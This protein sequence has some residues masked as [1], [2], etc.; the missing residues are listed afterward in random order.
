MAI[1]PTGAIYKSLI[2]DGESSRNYG[3]YITGQA[4]YNAPEREVEMISI[5]GRNGQFALDKGRF[6]N[7]EVT[8]PA[9]IFA[10]SETDFAEAISDF[11]NLLCSRRGYVRL[12]DEYNPNEYRMAIYKSGLEVE[13]AQLRA[14]QFEITF[15]CKPQ[16][17]L[18][19]GET[20]MAVPSNTAIVN[21]TLFEARP[22]LRV[23][24]Y[25]SVFL[26]DESITVNNVTLEDIVLNSGTSI[27]FDVQSSA[28]INLTLSMGGMQTGD[29]FRVSGL[30]VTETFA[31]YATGSSQVG[32]VN[33]TGSYKSA[34]STFPASSAAQVTW[35]YNDYDFAYGTPKTVTET[36]S[37]EI[38]AR[39]GQTDETWTYT[40]TMTLTYSGLT[41][42]SFS[43]Q[44]SPSNGTATSVP[45]G[46][47]ARTRGGTAT[48]PQVVGTP[49]LSN[50]IKYIDLDIGECYAYIDS[51]PVSF[52]SA[53]T[54][55]AILPTLKPGSTTITYDN[56]ITLF[57]IVP[58]WWK[59]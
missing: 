6:E 3:V 39:V 44:F 34:S 15:D 9:G 45:S 14:G 55:P 26:G 7:I 33:V 59:V 18:T 17:F 56:T 42:L 43:L 4:V 57:R 13:P 32:A 11:R 16:R 10:D 25:G 53:A 35:I 46:I 20:E 52:N 48:I 8:Y 21:P 41:R 31:E 27:D 51:E 5:P 36:L 29:A 2:F 38:V 19:S 30:K 50:L 49:T 40:R 37:F 54:F 22:E 24:G 47:T 23:R 58:R 1:A 12:T 28:G